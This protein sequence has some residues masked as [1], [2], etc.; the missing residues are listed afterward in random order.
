MAETSEVF[1]QAVEAFRQG[2]HDAALAACGTLLPLVTQPVERAAIFN[3]QGVCLAAKGDMFAA[4]DYLQSALE[5]KPEDAVLRHHAAQVFIQLGRRETALENA[6]A[7]SRLEPGNLGYRYQLARVQFSCG[8]TAGAW[9]ALQHCIAADHTFL[10]AWLFLSELAAERD[11]RALALDCLEKIVG[12]SPGHARAWTAIA[13]LDTGAERAASALTAL[14]RIAEQ[15][16]DE[17]TAVSAK[18]FLAEQERASGHHAAAFTLCRQANDCMAQ[19]SPFDLERWEGAVASTIEAFPIQ[20]QVQPQL[21]QPENAGQ[22]LIFIV[23][24]PRSGTSLCEQI[25]TAHPVVAGGGELPLMD[26]I[27]R[28]YWRDGVESMP[29]P[30]KLAWMALMR[31][32]YVRALP[33]RQKDQGRVTDKAPRNF[34]RLG[35]VF[36]LF[37]AARVIWM[38]RHPLDTLVSCYFQDFSP[39]Q[40]YSNRLDQCARVYHGHLRLMRHWQQC[41]GP[42]IRIVRYE[43][44]VGSLELEVS[45]LCDFLDLPFASPMLAPHKNPR[46]VRTASSEQVKQPV[47]TSAIG[48]WRHYANELAEPRAWFV[49]MGLLD[50]NGESRTPGSL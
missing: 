41:Y 45:A 20:P 40:G 24:M 14:G 18:F 32:Q 23:G 9:E 38:L 6:L 26:Y 2:R 29:D 36:S 16:V 33:F 35:L 5:L 27:D 15:A 42:A 12:Q 39:G 1:K 8:D 28:A 19:R 17:D 47:Y 7:A 31:Q 37:P 48:S 43:Q 3:L 25:L 49:S 10:E 34:E 22:D 46:Q 21:A 30:Q 11:D 50:A 4:A 13:S 44:L